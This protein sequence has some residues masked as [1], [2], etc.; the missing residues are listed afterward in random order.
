MRDLSSK[1]I[2]L[3]SHE[4]LGFGNI[5]ANKSLGSDVDKVETEDFA[6]KVERTGSLEIAFYNFEC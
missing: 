1:I 3:D 2:A 4:I 5:A 6:H